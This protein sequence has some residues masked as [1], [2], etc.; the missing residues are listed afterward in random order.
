MD[1]QLKLFNPDEKMRFREA[2]TLKQLP[3]E[4]RAKVR[5]LFAA[6]A[7]KLLRATQ[8]RNGRDESQHEN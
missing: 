5:D 3:E 2:Q 1:A 4:A 8:E 6:L 7:I